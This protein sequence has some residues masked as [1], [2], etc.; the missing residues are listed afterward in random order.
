MLGAMMLNKIKKANDNRD[1]VNRLMALGLT[2]KA[3][4]IFA[5]RLTNACKKSGCTAQQKETVNTVA[6]QI[7]ALGR[8]T[9][10]DIRTLVEN[11][12]YLAHQIMAFHGYAHRALVRHAAAG[13][14]TSDK[15]INAVMHRI[16][17]G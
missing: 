1:G 11:C 5:K 9:D 2:K 15:F 16:K 14:Y 17:E 12:P 10:D 6:A 7:I 3:A 13:R 4:R 8:A